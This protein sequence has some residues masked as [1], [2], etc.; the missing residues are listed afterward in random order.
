MAIEGQTTANFPTEIRDFYD[1]VALRKAVPL[2]TFR[3]WGQKRTL[4]RN[5]GK[6]VLFKR[7]GT[8]APATTPLAEGVTPVGNKMDY[9]EIR[10]T[11]QQYGDWIPVT[12]QVLMTS[13][14]PFLTE[15]SEQLGEQEGETHDILMR[16]DLL[17]GSNVV[18]ANDVSGRTNVVAKVSTSDL[19]I[20]IRTLKLANAR[21]ITK[22]VNPTANYNTAP[23]RA[24]YI[25]IIHP[26]QTGDVE[27]LTGFVPVENYP[28]SVSVMDGEIGSY[29]GIRFIE[30]TQAM[31]Y[32]GGGGDVADTIK[33]TA[34]KADVYPMLVFAEDAYGEIPLS[35][36][37]H[38]V[39][40]KVHG[41][42]D[43]Y[44][45]S[46]PLNQRG[47]IGWKSMWVGKILNDAWI[48]RYECAVSA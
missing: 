29:R 4:P 31:C 9:V 7:W 10:A 22:Q 43:R 21:K 16:N 27:A 25:A 36:S 18:Y 3:K 2:I 20:I 15:A 6:T 12:D 8:L 34:S 40:I 37:N 28:S 5:K 13:I 11:I 38:G 24:G 14:D 46:D 47:S 30:T 44:D 41:E 26:Y 17:S 35:G 39:I 48:V 33:N 23:I 45:T 32:E 1:R 19:D 42:N